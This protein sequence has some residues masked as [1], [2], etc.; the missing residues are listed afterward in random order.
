MATKI[1]IPNGTTAEKKA[2]LKLQLTEAK[3]R[4]AAIEAALKQLGP[5]KKKAKPKAYDGDASYPK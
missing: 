1:T 5:A 2:S 4:V 3:A